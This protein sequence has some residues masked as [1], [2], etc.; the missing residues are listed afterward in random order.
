MINNI[1]NLRK[2]QMELLQEFA[3]VCESHQLKWYAFFGTLLG[4]QRNEGYLPWD[5]DIDVVMPMED[6]LDLSG[7]RNLGKTEPRL[8]RM[9][10]L[11]A[12]RQKGIRGY[13]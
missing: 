8:F 3:N 11:N 5:D 6:Y 13:Q 4:I 10:S 2:V 7:L 1:T 12:S 9:I